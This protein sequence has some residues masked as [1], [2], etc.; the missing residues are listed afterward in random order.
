MGTG[1]PDLAAY[2]PKPELNLPSPWSLPLTMLATGKMVAV[3]SLSRDSQIFRYQNW[4]GQIQIPI[5]TPEWLTNV[6]PNILDNL[7]AG[8]LSLDLSR[9]HLGGSLT[10]ED[11]EDQ[12]FTIICDPHFSYVPCGLSGE[13]EVEYKRLAWI[14]DDALTPISDRTCADLS[15]RFPITPPFVTFNG[16]VDTQKFPLADDPS[17]GLDEITRNSSAV[18][19][20]ANYVYAMLPKCKAHMKK[21]CEDYRVET[22]PFRKH[23]KKAYITGYFHGFCNKNT[24]FTSDYPYNPLEF[25]PLIEIIKVDWAAGEP[26][27]TAA[28]RDPFSTPSKGDMTER[29]KGKFK[30]DPLAQMSADAKVP[31]PLFNN[32]SQASDAI[33]DNDDPFSVNG[34]RDVA[35]INI[36]RSGEVETIEDSSD[37]ASPTKRPKR[38]SLR[39]RK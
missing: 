19:R 30:F 17:V 14:Q 20:Y 1:K 5:H 26:R 33:V 12:W 18:F 21:K 39:G 27:Q 4:S 36:K 24:V 29:T 11:W 23:G 34:L 35:P 6:F 10:T 32:G 37:G 15:P 7:H 9:F 16:F 31:G 22:T 28:S 8:A 13:D 38:G 3:E 2:W 25:V